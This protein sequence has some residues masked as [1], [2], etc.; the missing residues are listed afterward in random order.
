MIR[1]QALFLF[2]LLLVLHGCVP[3]EPQGGQDSNGVD[4][5][6]VEKDLITEDYIY[7]P[8]IKTALLYPN[9]YNNDTNDVFAPPMLQPPLIP[10]AQTN[11]LLLEFD[12][13]GT[14][15]Q[16]YYAKII[17]CNAD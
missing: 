11:Q 2:V 4:V 12:E 13:M 5:K 3:V 7:E 17:N 1:I 6:V 10:M 8:Q 15:T 9:T 14:Y 16:S